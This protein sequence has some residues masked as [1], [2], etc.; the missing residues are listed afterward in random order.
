MVRILFA[1]RDDDLSSTG[2]E[3][4]GWAQGKET[5]VPLGLLRSSS[6]FLQAATKPE[7]DTLRDEKHTV[8]LNSD[9]MLIKAYV[10]KRVASSHMYLYRY[11]LGPL[12]VPGH[13]PSTGR[14][15]TRPRRLRVSGETTCLGR[16]THGRS[17]QEYY[18]RCPQSAFPQDS[19]ESDRTSGQDNLR[20]HS[21]GLACS[22]SY[23]RLLCPQRL[24]DAMK[25]LISIR[26]GPGGFRGGVD[27]KEYH[28]AV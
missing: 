18:N 14:R 23:G 15:F 21:G 11:G 28:E 27:P 24:I 1:P 19:K 8:T 20:W 22:T 9:S 12:A 25:R 26:P 17:L 2:M 4:A 3:Q 10:S 5:W 6:Q 7:W 13:I 16:G